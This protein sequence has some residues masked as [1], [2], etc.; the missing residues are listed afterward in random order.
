MRPIHEKEQSAGTTG[1]PLGSNLGNLLGKILG[2]FGVWILVWMVLERQ[3]AVRLPDLYAAGIWCNAQCC[4]WIKWFQC[5]QGYPRLPAA[6]LGEHFLYGSTS[7][8]CTCSM[9]PTTETRNLTSREAQ[10]VPKA[11]EHGM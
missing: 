8:R 1:N 2:S 5:S 4:I 11:M 7:F 10:I 9:D 6:V 3:A